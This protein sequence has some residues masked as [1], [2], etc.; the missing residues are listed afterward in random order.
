[1]VL[2]VLQGHA[3]EDNY[4]VEVAFTGEIAQTGQNMGSAK[5]FSLGKL[6]HLMSDTL[7]CFGQYYDDVLASG[8]TMAT[9]QP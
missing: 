2:A 4:E 8:D 1:M 7:R 6:L 3:I 5:I 9:S